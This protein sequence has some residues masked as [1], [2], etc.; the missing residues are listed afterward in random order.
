MGDHSP[1]N[2]RLKVNSAMAIDLGNGTTRRQKK[3]VLSLSMPTSCVD[4]VK[5]G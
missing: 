2:P 1:L 3:I 5:Y 4:C